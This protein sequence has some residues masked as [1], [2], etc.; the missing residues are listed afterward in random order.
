MCTLLNDKEAELAVVKRKPKLLE[1]KQWKL[2]IALL[3]GKRS[4]ALSFLKQSWRNSVRLKLSGRSLIENIDNLGKTENGTEE[5]LTRFSRE[6]GQK[7]LRR[8][9]PDLTAEALN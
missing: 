4:F 6:D 5:E 9:T 7:S 3:A 1:A 8:D 2:A